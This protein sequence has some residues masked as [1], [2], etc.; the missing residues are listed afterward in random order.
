MRVRRLR[1]GL[2]SGLR[3]GA[4]CR[5]P[6]AE[7]RSWPEGCAR[8]IPRRLRHSAGVGVAGT[9]LRAPRCELRR[10]SVARPPCRRRPGRQA[11]PKP[12]PRPAR[13]R[14]CIPRRGAGGAPGA[15]SRRRCP[16]RRGSPPRPATRVLRRDD[17]SRRDRRT[18]PHQQNPEAG[19]EPAE[20]ACGEMPER[21]HHGLR[22]TFLRSL[23]PTYALR[24]GATTLIGIK[25]RADGRGSVPDLAPVCWRPCNAKGQ[26]RGA[27]IVSC[28]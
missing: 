14:G 17:A 28:R 24:D 22:E 3:H 20:H 1:R 9:V 26:G 25:S 23:P 27:P 13:S 21:R 6:R 10:R 8:K 4:Y 7:A 16:R 11:E 19:A 18:M 15:G 2:F 12:G 5:C